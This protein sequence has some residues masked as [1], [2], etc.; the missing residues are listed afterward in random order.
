M[1]LI[2]NFYIAIVHDSDYDETIISNTTKFFDNFTEARLWLAKTCKER[3]RELYK[4]G[5]IYKKKSLYGELAHYY[6]G[7]T[8]SYYT[9]NGYC[10]E[11]NTKEYQLECES[12][13]GIG[14]P[15]N[16]GCNQGNLIELMPEDEKDWLMNY[17]NPNNKSNVYLYDY[18][19]KKVWGILTGEYKWNKTK[20]DWEDKLE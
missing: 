20:R 3:A 12:L 9:W 7:R 10:H 11:Y 2:P 13:D 6:A 19:H 17:L 8:V 16:D 5:R 18:K 4:L 14:Y 1:E 15:R